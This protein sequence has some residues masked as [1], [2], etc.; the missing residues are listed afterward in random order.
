MASYQPVAQSESPAGDLLLADETFASDRDKSDAS[1]HHKEPDGRRHNH[2]LLSQTASN[3]SQKQGLVRLGATDSSKIKAN[4]SHLPAS[5]TA[6]TSEAGPASGGANGAKPNVTFRLSDEPE[7]KV[8]SPFILLFSGKP[9]ARI[10]S[11][12]FTTNDRRSVFSIDR[13]TKWATATCALR[14]EIDNVAR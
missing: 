13:K 8:L 1:L 12:T 10:S 14:R 4:A 5:A 11:C 3:T 9:G 2:Y 7:S 6:P